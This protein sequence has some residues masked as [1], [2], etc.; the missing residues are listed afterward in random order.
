MKM[1]KNFRQSNFQVV[2]CFKSV[3][4]KTQL[5]H[6]NDN[7]TIKGKN[8]SLLKK[9]IKDNIIS[10]YYLPTSITHLPM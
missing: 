10:L 2:K 4:V 7:I 9:Q 8:T 1:G 6:V 3:F 5:D